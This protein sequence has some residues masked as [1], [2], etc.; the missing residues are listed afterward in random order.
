MK[1]KEEDQVVAISGNVPVTPPAN[2]GDG[3]CARVPCTV[4]RS[5]NGLFGVYAVVRTRISLI[6][7][8]EGTHQT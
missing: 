8:Q 7:T 2:R 1:T 4:E 5:A 6:G 3:E